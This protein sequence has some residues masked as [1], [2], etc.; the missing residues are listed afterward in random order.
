M[1]RSAR[2]LPPLHPFVPGISQFALDLRGPCHRESCF[3]L[4]GMQHAS[5]TR[6]STHGSS[7]CLIFALRP[8]SASARAIGGGVQILNAAARGDTVT[9]EQI[10]ADGDNRETVLA[11][12][13]DLGR[14]ALHLS[15]AAGHKDVVAQLL[16]AGAKL[17]AQDEKQQI[18]LVAAS[19]HGHASVVEQLLQAG[20]DVT[21]ASSSGSTPL[22]ASAAAGHVDVLQLELLLRAGAA[23]NTGVGS[24]TGTAL[25]VAAEHGHTSALEVLLAAAADVNAVD[26]RSS[27]PLH[28]AAAAGH[29]IVVS[30]LL[31]AGAAVNAADEANRTA[32]FAAVESN[33]ADAVKA[34]LDAGADAITAAEGP[35][36]SALQLAAT[37]AASI[38]STQQVLQCFLD[39]Y[40]M[41]A[42][43]GTPAAAEAL[44]LAALAVADSRG[45]RVMPESD[46]QQY[47]SVTRK[48]LL[49]AA[50]QDAAATQAA[51]Q[52]HFPEARGAGATVAAALMEAY[53]ETAAAVA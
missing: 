23:V 48:L 2:H 7:P 52:Q 42:V 6:A 27:T 17:N 35:S 19:A 9:V 22:H 33:H 34:L 30:T 12:K 40:T 13:D 31:K 1:G 4:R 44:V 49:A 32:L 53:A 5:T 28:R 25:H 20:A 51:L 15:A 8:M 14:T 46:A 45:N 26:S 11:G 38:P 36:H 29:L 43:P 24:E 39:H 18:A 41:A 3:V 47:R 21:A 37:N 50:K 10:L 16:A